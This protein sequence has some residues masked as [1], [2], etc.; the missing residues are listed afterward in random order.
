MSVLLVSCWSRLVGVAG[1]TKILP[2]GITLPYVETD[3]LKSEGFD[4]GYF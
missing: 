2:H 4:F 1:Q 3:Q